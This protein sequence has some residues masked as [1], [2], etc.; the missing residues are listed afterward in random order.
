MKHIP[1]VLAIL[2]LAGLGPCAEAGEPGLRIVV[3]ENV[4]AGMARAIAG[5]EASISAILSNPNQDPHEFEASPSTAR[6]IADAGLVIYNGAGYD[7]WMD[8]LLRAAFVPGRRV[9]VAADLLGH[10]PGQNPHFWYDPSALPRLAQAL[11]GELARRDPGQTG[12]YE[13]RLKAYLASLQP[14]GEKIAELRRKYAGLEVTATE[15]V[16]GYMAAALGLRMHNESFQRSV[17]NGTEPSA[18]EVAAFEGDLRNRKVRVLFYN[19]QVSDGLTSRLRRLAEEANIP[20]VGVS[21]TQPPGLGYPD[22]MLD[23]LTALERALSGSGS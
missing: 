18:S 3:G 22:W 6:L 15:P 9:I 23:Q 5:G 21:E 13:E 4:Y 10:R 19:N 1:I 7:P 8:S 11:A 20:V 14:L 12:M 2:I 16:F 17:M